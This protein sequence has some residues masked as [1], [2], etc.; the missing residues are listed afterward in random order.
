MS[1]IYSF[2]LNS[3]FSIKIEKPFVL[4]KHLINSVDKF[5]VMNKGLFGNSFNNGNIYFLVKHNEK[6]LTIQLGK[7]KYALAR[8]SHAKRFNLPVFNYKIDIN[9][10]AVTG[11]LVC[12]DGLVIG[13][14]ANTVG[15]DTNL[16]EPAPACGLCL[17]NPK[18]QLLDELNTEIG[19]SSDSIYSIQSRG[20]VCDVDSGVFDIVYVLYTLL[21]SN[22]IL[23]YKKK[24]AT[25]EYSELSFV[26]IKKINE[27]IEKNDKN[28][29][30]AF[31]NM[32]HLSRL[33]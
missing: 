20:L 21:S 31:K 5:W 32:L 26:K 2:N 27:F 4:P 6:Q 14:R 8:I 9:P 19:L 10:L 15:T 13:K 18:T 28:L 17:P 23:K 25:D 29:I 30:P 22:E 3:N 11:V 24:L 7:Y 12:K 33:I 1:K 16:W